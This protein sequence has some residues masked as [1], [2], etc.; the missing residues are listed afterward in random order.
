MAVITWAQFLNL[1]SQILLIRNDA[2]LL[3]FL[4]TTNTIM[5]RVWRIFNKI[6]ITWW[7]DSC[8]SSGLST[9]V[10]ALTCGHSAE[11]LALFWQVCA[12][13]C[14]PSLYSHLSWLRFFI[15]SII[16]VNLWSMVSNLSFCCWF[17]RGA[18]VLGSRF[19]AVH[20]PDVRC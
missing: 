17:C 13:I 5:P 2:F 8:C 11:V 9:K 20:V 16:T 12:A 6:I 3:E 7:L 10:L 15:A 4:L 14:S 18:Q 19:Q 1:V